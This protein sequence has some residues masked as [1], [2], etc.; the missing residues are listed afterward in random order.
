M[1]APY[2][3]SGWADRVGWAGRGRPSPRPRRLACLV[4]VAEL[5][6]VVASALVLHVVAPGLSGTGAALVVTV[7]LAVLVTVLVWRV[8][9]FRAAGFTGPRGWRSVGLFVVPALLVPVPLLAG[10][11]PVE[12][13]TVWVLVAGYA[14]TGFME[15]ALWRG[16]VLRVLRPTGART[17]VLLSSVLFGAAHLGNVLFRDNVALVVAQAVGAACF[18]VG[19]AA[20]ALRTGTIV[21]LML[22]H[23][24]TDLCAAVGG[25]PKIPVLVG[26]DV[27][28]LVLGLVIL[29]H[30]TDVVPPAR[31][32]GPAQTSNRR[33][34]GPTWA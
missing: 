21:P 24:L 4:L 28:L 19:Y 31:P 7:V 18:G 9:G 1:R 12:A 23:M 20:V 8:T 5:L 10:V 30:R 15:E 14:L 6:A 27:V 32:T 29:R 33:L 26:Q 3:R 16:V 2:T 13:G 34:N 25:L 17:A 11:R 22:L